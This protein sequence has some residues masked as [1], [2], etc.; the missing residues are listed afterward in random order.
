MRGWGLAGEEKLGNEACARMRMRDGGN[1][2]GGQL[3]GEQR[4][5]GRMACASRWVQ[6]KRAGGGGGERRGEGRSE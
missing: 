1:T 2:E 6:V 5:V 4:P 3:K